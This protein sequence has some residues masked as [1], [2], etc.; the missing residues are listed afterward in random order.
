MSVKIFNDSNIQELI[1]KYDDGDS[2]S[3]LAKHYKTST[4]VVTQTLKRAGVTLRTASDNAKRRLQKYG[5]PS[6]G[7]T[8]SEETRKKMRDNHAN[9]KGAN[10]PRFQGK[11]VYAE[12]GAYLCPDGNGYLRRLMPSHPLAQ[13]DGYIGEHIFQACMKWGVDAV[14]GN[15]IHHVNEDKSDCSWDNLELKSRVE[16]MR[17]HCNPLK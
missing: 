4:H 17:H 15:D 3:E 7:R 12:D 1:K 10:H 9:F 16:H 2:A 8:H 13:K 6:V 5:H 11:G 14:R